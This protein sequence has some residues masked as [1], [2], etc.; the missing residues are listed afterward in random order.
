MTKDLIE[1][2]TCP[3]CGV[4]FNDYRSNKRVFC[5][6]HCAGKVSARTHGD[7]R[8]KLY[9]VWYWMKQRCSQSSHA[10]QFYADR[11]ITICKEWSESYESFK[12]WALANGY[13]EG[14]ELD[15][16]NT[17]GN[18]EPDNC[19]WATRQQ[20]MANTRK[21]NDGQTSRYKGVSRWQRKWR[22]QISRDG[23]NRH[24]GCFATAVEAAFAYD[25]AAFEAS[26]EFAH[27]NFPERLN[28]KEVSH[29]GTFSKEG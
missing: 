11:G 26:G 22:A 4:E 5:S 13:R 15:R 3:V 19:R 8:I 20:Q 28:R 12:S 24:I 29:L 14:L 6:R 17:N 16:R 7:S 9:Q 10:S 23:V 27:V 2:I 18:Y 1:T 25:D 21:R